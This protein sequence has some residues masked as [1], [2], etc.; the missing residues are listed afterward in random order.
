MI[1]IISYRSNRKLIYKRWV[2]TFSPKNHL[3]NGPELVRGLWSKK[4]PRIL[5]VYILLIFPF[6]SV[7]FIDGQKCLATTICFKQLDEERGAER[8]FPFSWIN[9]SESAHI[10]SHNFGQNFITWQ[11]C[12]RGWKVESLFV[13]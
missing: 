8:S 11:C 10:I 5:A 3:V 1:I 9:D 4:L 6:K 7:A 13:Y 12:K 2:I